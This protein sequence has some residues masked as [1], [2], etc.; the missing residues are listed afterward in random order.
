M[1]FYIKIFSEIL[2]IFL[3]IC[4]NIK[5]VLI[6]QENRILKTVGGLSVNPTEECAL[7]Y[8]NNDFVSFLAKIGK[9]F[10]MLFDTIYLTFFGGEIYYAK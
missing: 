8:L 1:Q 4:Y 3:L 10:F 9:G 6:Q 5:A 7:S 2:D